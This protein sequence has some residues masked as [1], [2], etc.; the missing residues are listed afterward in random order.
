V[1]K[2]VFEV[3]EGTIRNVGLDGIERLYAFLPLAGSQE[4]V[5]LLLGTPTETAFAGVNQKTLH[6]LL[7]LGSVILAALIAAWFLGGVFV[8]RQIDS[9]VDI[10]QRLASGDL[11]ARTL[12]NYDQGEFG[13]LN[14]AV[15]EMAESLSNREQERKKADDAIREY[16]ASLEMSNRDLM[17]FANIASH[18]LQEPLRK[19]STFS[20]MLSSRYADVL[21][22]QG[23]DYLNRIRSSARHLQA[24]IIDLLSYSRISTKSKPLD[25]VDLNHILKD[26]LVDYELKIEEKKADIK[27]QDLPILQADPTQMHQLFFNLLG[28]SLKFTKPDQA[29]VIQITSRL[30]RSPKGSQAELDWCEI[31]VT[32]QG[33]GFNEKYLDRLF[34]PFQRLHD[35]ALY[36]GNGMGLAICRKIVERHGGE[37]T[38]ESQTGQ[39]A[40]FIVRLPLINE[41]GMNI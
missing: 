34:Q 23:N 41:R 26:V 1:L 28:N 16:A 38:A 20:D 37:I 30:I 40:T 27:I 5:F 31:K 17:D 13:V 39:G 36:E 7:L 21:D 12:G 6:N 22:N 35:H 3:R 8:V 10:T 25:Q 15:D 18:D 32:D 11:S 19:I 4:S 14:R 29:V 9:L 2:T 33:V 24:L